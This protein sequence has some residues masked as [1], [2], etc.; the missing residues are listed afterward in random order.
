M[1]EMN[2]EII[3]NKDLIFAC[4]DQ[5]YYNNYGKIFT[6][7]ALKNNNIVHIHIMDCKENIEQ[8]E[9]CTIT[10]EFDANRNQKKVDTYSGINFTEAQVEYACGRFIYLPEILKRAKSV[11]VLDIDAV[12]RKHIEFPKTDFSFF[13]R[14]NRPE[15]SK[16]AAGAVY[17]KNNAIEIANYLKMSVE[18]RPKRWFS[19]QYALLDT[20]NQFI[21]SEYTF[22]EIPFSLIDYN[23]RSDSS[24]WTGKG[25][26]KFN[27]DRFIAEMEKYK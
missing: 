21:N 2:W 6:Q 16:V 7:S 17:I 10:Y 9:G 24:V 25:N 27:D 13:L 1:K 5:K 8:I 18:K 12:I 19:D 20:Y 15:K 26:K 22:S 3:P 23:F 4:C 11:L 14:K